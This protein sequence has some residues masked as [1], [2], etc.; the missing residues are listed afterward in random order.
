MEFVKHFRHYLHGQK[1]HIRTD[2]APLR[3]VLKV[4]E[5]EAQLA[6][7]TEFLSPFEYE[8]EYRE[9]QRHSNADAMS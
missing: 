1:F 3:S 6:R 7:W 2:H 8:I 4:K 9:G 5:P